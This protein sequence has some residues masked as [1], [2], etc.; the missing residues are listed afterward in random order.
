MITIVEL[1]RN[2][3]SSSRHSLNLHLKQ[4]HWIIVEGGFEPGF[5]YAALIAPPLFAAARPGWGTPPLFSYLSQTWLSHI[6]LYH[7][8]SFVSAAQNSIPTTNRHSLV[9]PKTTLD[10]LFPP[11]DLLDCLSSEVSRIVSTQPPP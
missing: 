10:Q 8:S 6:I 4:L 11:E 5:G 2:L 3:G 1:T 9:K 7:V